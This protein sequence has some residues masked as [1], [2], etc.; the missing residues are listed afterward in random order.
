MISEIKISVII[1]IH[2]ID[3][4]YLKQCLNSLRSQTLKEFE[5]HLILND[6]TSAEK[7]I[8]EKVCIDDPR[9]NFFETDIADVSTA[10]NIGLNHVQGKYVTFL[11]CDDWLSKDALQTLL[12]LMEQNQTEIGIANAQKIW[13]NGKKKKLFN[14]YNHTEPTSLKHIFHTGVWSYIFKNN[15]IQTN[16][17]RFQEGLKLSEDRVFLFEYYLHC[18]KITFNDKTIYFYRQHGA[19]VCKTKHTHEHAIQQIKA[20]NA[21]REILA[22]SPEFSQRD[23]HH[24]ERYLTRMG[25]IA[26]INSGTTK[27]GVS[28]LK[29]H[30]LNHICDSKLTFYYCWYRAKLSSLAGKLLHL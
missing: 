27:D 26:Y 19:S 20:A 16:H 9:F 11:D 25:M 24:L 18:K 10:R 5:A 12:D 29:A 8:V 2:R 21:L 28:Q 6:S 17:I 3:A 7:T 4:S 1:P 15:I 13:E 23:I 14:F 30:F 22:N